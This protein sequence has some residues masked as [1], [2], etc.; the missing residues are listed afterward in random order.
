MLVWAFPLQNTG[1]HVR[2]L[3]NHIDLSNISTG[4]SGAVLSNMLTGIYG[5]YMYGSK[6]A[7]NEINGNDSINIAA[8]ENVHGINL[9]NCENQTLQCNLIG[10]TRFGIGAIS[11]CKTDSVSGVVGNIMYDQ[12]LGW[13]FRHL[14]TEGSF[15]NVGSNSN[16]N[17]NLFLGSNYN[18]KVFKFCEGADLYKIFTDT[19]KLKNTESGSYDYITM[20]NDCP[21][22]VSLNSGATLYTCPVNYNFLDISSTPFDHVDAIKIITNTK[23]YSE[24]AEISHWIDSRKL[25]RQLQED[26]TFRNSNDTLHNFHDTAVATILGAALIAEENISSMIV[27]MSSQDHNLYEQRMKDARDNNSNIVSE[28]IQDVNEEAINAIF[29]KM[30]DYGLDTLD[31]EDSTIINTLAVQCPYIG[32]TAVFKARSLQAMFEPAMVY[33]DISLCNTIGVYK[34][35]NNINTKGIFDD[36]NAYLKSLQLKNNRLASKYIGSKFMLYP[37]PASTNITIAYDLS[38]NEN[39]FVV[40]YD[41]L[42]RKLMVIDLDESN[43]KVSVNIS[44]LQHG[45]FTY[46]YLVN[47][48]QREAGKLLIQ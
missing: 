38:S 42:G 36:E 10:K 26:T 48:I 46:K 22:D 45:I 39:G 12:V 21:Y 25:F 29:L 32:G 5:T 1:S 19:S 11:D 31:S 16:D 4:E 9:N 44:S 34:Q 28:E 24:Y 20:M 15:R 14:G 2:V 33:D 30:M 18:H 3:Q 6:I 41:I 23:T 13:A 35:G 27:S 37:N 7:D 17:N 43:N 40:V 47:K 8:R